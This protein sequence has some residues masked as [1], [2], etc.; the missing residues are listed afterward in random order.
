MTTMVEAL[1][2]AR[3]ALLQVELY[4]HTNW[5]RYTTGCG[6]V[7]FVEACAWCHQRKEHTDICQREIAL[8][9]I[10]AAL[11]PFEGEE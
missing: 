10:E 5:I 6:N 8:E 4:E 1:K 11:G 9:A 3:K 7:Y 2:E